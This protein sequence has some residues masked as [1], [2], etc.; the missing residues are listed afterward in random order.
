MA[1][2]IRHKRSSVPGKIPAPSQLEVGE[3]AINCADKVLYTKDSSNLIVALN[4]WENIAN[5]PAIGQ[6]IDGLYTGNSAPLATEYAY[7]WD[8]ALRNFSVSALG[9]WQQCDVGSVGEIIDVPAAQTREYLTADRTYY[10]ASTGSNSNNGLTAGM[11]FAT[12]QYAVDF[13]ANNIDLGGRTVII[14]LADGTFTESV[15]LRQLVGYSSVASGGVIIQGNQSNI[16]AVTVQ[17]D[18]SSWWAFA[19]TSAEKGYWLRYMRLQNSAA[20]GN[21]LV[22]ARN[23]IVR[24]SQINF[25]SSVAAHMF[26]YE[27]GQVEISGGYLISGGAQRHMLSNSKGNIIFVTTQTVTITG[28]LTFSI[29]FARAALSGSIIYR[30]TVTYSGS[31][32]GKRYEATLLGLVDTNGAGTSYLPGSTA[33]TTG[34]GG[35]YF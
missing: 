8:Q 16:S 26:V 18:G 2:R 11:P 13:V 32:N 19:S 31:A 9:T 17:G 23:S 27:G 12:I 10:V 34:T 24:I 29:V 33:G 3:L 22:V 4:D 30:G 1:S 28:S 21:S 35:I 14:Q 25:G 20:A 5:K 7:W 15:T 6:S